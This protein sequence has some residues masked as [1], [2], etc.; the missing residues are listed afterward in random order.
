MT[1]MLQKLL[2]GDEGKYSSSTKAVLELVGLGLQDQT[3][4]HLS[5]V[6]I[7]G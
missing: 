7:Q 5:W 2:R 1:V 3:L 6:C 4:E